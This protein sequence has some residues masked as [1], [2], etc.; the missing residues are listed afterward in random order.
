MKRQGP[1]PALRH[2][3]AFL[4]VSETG[5]FT[6]AGANLRR[7]VSAVSRSVALLE[8]MFEHSLLE[9]GA[10]HHDLTAEGQAVALRCAI[11]RDEL[12]ACRDQVLRYHGARVP[13]SSALFAMMVDCIHLR[14]LVVVR[15]FRSVQRAANAL[16]VSQPAVSYSVCLLEAEVGTALFTR[17]PS[18]MIATP[19]GESVSLSA[20]RILSELARMT[21]D[22]HSAKGISSGLVCVGALAYSRSAVLPGAIRN[23][24]VHHPEISVRTVEGHIDQLVAALHGGEV[25]ALLCALPDR[26]LLDGVDIEPFARDRMGLFVRHG[27]PLAHCPSVPLAALLEYD[28][29]LPPQGTITRKL[30]EGF[31]RSYGLPMP[32]G[33]VETSSYSLVRALLTG[34]NLIAFRTRREFAPDP[35]GSTVTSLDLAVPLPERDICFLRRKGAQPTAALQTFLQIVRET[36]RS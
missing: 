13:E 2:F 30:L 32:Q 35:T 27:H 12:R 1:M 19:A 16:S 8:A 31:F 28:F 29:I 11:I 20:R 14:A 24:L 21:D 26:S 23:I 22:V 25:D 3:R 33:R 7:S 36:V 5:S 6:V 18:G 9:R 10:A 34:S 4:A 17:L 15:D